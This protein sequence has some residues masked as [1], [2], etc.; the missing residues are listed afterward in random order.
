MSIHAIRSGLPL[1]L[2]L[3]ACGPDGGEPSVAGTV[4][5]EIA[6]CSGSFRDGQAQMACAGGCSWADGDLAIDGDLGSYATLRYGGNGAVISASA[7]APAGTSFPAG[8]FAG[9]ILRFPTPNGL[10]ARSMFFRTWLAG[11]PMEVFETSDPLDGPQGFDEDQ[12]QRY[13]FKTTLPFDQIEIQI[14]THGVLDPYLVRIYEF[15]GA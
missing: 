13:G 15:C 7:R 12:D 11:A 9:A 14:T 8:N 2:L 6:A 3:S 4:P 1:M 10:S 5:Q